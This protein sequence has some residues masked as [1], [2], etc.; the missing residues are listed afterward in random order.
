M[1]KTKNTFTTD[2]LDDE[3]AGQIPDLSEPGGLG[4]PLLDAVALLRRL[5]EQKRQVLA[6]LVTT[7]EDA[8]FGTS[9]LR[10]DPSADAQALLAGADL[11]T[12]VAPVAET[13]RATLLR[14]LRALERAIPEAEGRIGGIEAETI[15]ET[16]EAVRPVAQQIAQDTINAARHLLACLQAE[17]EFHEVLN[18]RGLR[19][20]RRPGWLRLWPQMAAWLDGDVHRPSLSH[21]IHERAVAAGLDAGG[22]NE[23]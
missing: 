1:P 16:C 17:R 7:S 11:A 6:E 19:H 23:S 10:H 2:L 14:Q 4:Q 20:D 13:R 21:F 8:G 12:M 22:A 18:R 3:I 15:L 5:Q 9:R